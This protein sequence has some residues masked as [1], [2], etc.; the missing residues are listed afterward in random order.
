MKLRSFQVENFRSIHRTPSLEIGSSLTLIGPNNEGK[1]NIVR[2]I[3]TALEILKWHSVSSMVTRSITMAKSRSTTSR[4]ARPIYS[5]EQDFPKDLQSKRAGSSNFKLVFELNDEDRAEF[6]RLIKSN[7]N[8]ELPIEITIGKSNPT[9]KVRKRGPGGNVLTSKS[10]AIARFVGERIDIN[11]IEAVRKAEDAQSVVDAVVSRALQPL[12]QLDE[13]KNAV[14][15]ILALQQPVLNEIQN[16]LAEALKNFLPSVD[17]VTIRPASDVRAAMWRSVEILIDDG[18]ETPLAQK[19]DGVISL[20]ALALLTGIGLEEGVFSS[21]KG[22]GN[23]VLALEEPE[24]HLHPNAIHYI[25]NVVDNI[26]SDKQIIITTHSPLLVNRANVASNIIV[27]SNNATP[28]TSVQQI[29]HSLGVRTADNLSSARLVMLL[30]GEDDVDKMKML[31]EKLD[32]AVDE[33]VRQG[34]VFLQ[35]LRGC[36]KLAYNVASLQSSVCEVIAFLDDD[37]AGRSAWDQAREANLLK[38]RD[39]FFTTAGGREEAELEDFLLDDWVN[40]VLAESYAVTFAALRRGERK[41]KFSDRLKCAFR[42]SGKPFDDEL[43]DEV[44]HLLTRRALDSG[45][46]AFDNERLA[47][48]RGAIAEVRRRLDGVAVG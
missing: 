44:K 12:E 42:N 21:A 14:A 19:G 45:L 24:S 26:A 37:Q 3:V 30:E 40:G 2:A 33:A 16:A 9:F 35:P 10:R 15:T 38:A 39:I 25:R 4:R 34:E 7:I 5:W 8:N 41:C 22:Y 46:A 31:I 32:E 18:Q 27:E 23:T 36:G 20:T 11:H 43:K 17:S 1:S 47:P 13:M 29:R 48:V 6:R 28:A